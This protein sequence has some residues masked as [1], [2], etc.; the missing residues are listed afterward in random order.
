MTSLSIIV[1][2]RTQP[3]QA[4]FLRK[5]LD[6][7][8]AQTMY[9]ALPIEVL[10]GLDLGASAPIE[11]AGEP[12]VRFVEAYARAQ[13]AALNAAIRASTGAFIAILEDDDR[14]APPYLALMLELAGQAPLVTT[15]ELE[16]DEAGMA[17]NISDCATP[18]AWVFQRTLWE[19]IGPFDDDHRY[20]FDCDWLGRV[21]QSGAAR[22]HIVEAGAPLD[23][24]AIARER[25]FLDTIVRQNAPNLRLARHDGPRPLVTRMRHSGA[26]M[27]MIA[28]QAGPAAQ[29][30]SEV[31]RLIARYGA[32]PR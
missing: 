1:P 14:W 27:R 29:S 30:R 10:I 18:S 20:H 26:G 25:P 16:V 2:S 9:G 21:R 23:T 13:V 22:I 32:T 24:G 28:T 12:G 3:K 7:I 11:L 15:N 19:H 17:L 6:S 31:Q 4:A 8:R 5:A